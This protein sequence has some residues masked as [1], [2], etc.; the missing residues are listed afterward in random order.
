MDY[1]AHRRSIRMAW[2]R[3]LATGD[4]VGERLA[5]ALR[6]LPQAS[7]AWP[8]SRGPGRDSGVNSDRYLELYL[9]AAWA[10]TV[11]VPLNIRWSLLENEDAM[12][13]CRATVLFVDKTF[14]A[15][16]AT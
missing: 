5:S 11:I 3:C 8:E 6:V 1:D 4:V 16:G 13:D 15:T 12:R 7:L 14:A 10:G 9:A 2:R